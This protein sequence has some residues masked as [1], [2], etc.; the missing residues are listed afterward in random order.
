ME[1]G[2]A[3]RAVDAA[4]RGRQLSNIFV[5]LVEYV[6]VYERGEKCHE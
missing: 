3:G 6:G 5:F 4:R 1:V 2:K